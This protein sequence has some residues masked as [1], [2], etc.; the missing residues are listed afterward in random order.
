[1]NNW[2]A[3]CESFS[4]GYIYGKMNG[5]ILIL[6]SLLVSGI[7]LAVVPVCPTLI[8]T[9][10]A[11]FVLGAGTG[12]IHIGKATSQLLRS[13]AASNLLSLSNVTIPIHMNMHICA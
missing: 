10:V 9:H 4:G 12:L 2:I 5:Q 7:A 11:C 13:E 6:A 1:M 8:W 3:Y